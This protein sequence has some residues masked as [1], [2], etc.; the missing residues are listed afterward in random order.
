LDKQNGAWTVAK[1][2]IGT[3]LSATIV[4]V[5]ILVLTFVAFIK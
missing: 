5:G 2:L 4:G 1:F 3:N